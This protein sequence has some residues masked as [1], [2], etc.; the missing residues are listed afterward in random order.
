MFFNTRP[1]LQYFLGNSVC[2]TYLKIV[3]FYFLLAQNKTMPSD[4]ETIVQMTCS[5][6]N[7]TTTAPTVII[8]DAIN[9]VD[10]GLPTFSF[11]FFNYEFSLYYYLSLYTCI[12]WYTTCIF[13]DTHINRGCLLKW[14]FFTPTHFKQFCFLYSTVWQGKSC[15]ANDMGSK[16]IGPKYKMHI[17]HDRR[18]P[19]AQSSFGKRVQT[20]CY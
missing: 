6:L 13:W 9:Q 1:S 17:L 11:Y 3:I 16:K 20:K 14:F 12:F 10:L 2:T 18:H 8:I 19:T 5:A 15:R 4:M 7:V